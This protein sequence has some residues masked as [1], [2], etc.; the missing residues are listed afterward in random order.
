MMLLILAGGFRVVLEEIVPPDHLSAY[1]VEADSIYTVRAVV[2]A[3]GETR[4]GTPKYLLRPEHIQRQSI[5]A[6]A[7]ILYA[8]E[9][10]SLLHEGDTLMAGMQINTPRPRRNPHEFDYRDYL[11]KKDIYFEAFLSD[12]EG[13]VIRSRKGS[14]LLLLMFDLKEGIS[15]HFHTYLTPRSA[16]I[17]SALILGDK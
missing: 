9:L 16:G 6:G 1:H 17:L 7:M 5:S 11:A 4:R 12:P 15:N 2:D 8:K 14:N 10:T 13:V 3:V